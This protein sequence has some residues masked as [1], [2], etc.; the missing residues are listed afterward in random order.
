MTG[1]LAFSDIVCIEG[2]KAE[3]RNKERQSLVRVFRV[4]H[5]NPTALKMAK[6]T[7]NAL[8]YIIFCTEKEANHQP[9][10]SRDILRL[11]VFSMREK[12]K[13]DLT[14]HSPIDSQVSPLE[15]PWRSCV[16]RA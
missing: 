3:R 1:E 8:K 4:A 6:A 7:K 14:P 2:E 16:D 9:L 5:L 11:S 15:H 10:F 13:V 12:V